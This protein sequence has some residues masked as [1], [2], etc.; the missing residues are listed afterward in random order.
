MYLFICACRVLPAACPAE[1]VV[2]Y[3]PEFCGQHLEVSESCASRIGYIFDCDPSAYI[4]YLKED[5]QEKILKI[6]WK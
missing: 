2:V 3:K 6:F 5:F 1:V 4:W